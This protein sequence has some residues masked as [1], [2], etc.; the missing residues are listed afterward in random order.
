M[1]R[2]QLAEARV[3]EERLEEI[4]R[5]AGWAKTFGLPLEL[6]SAAE[7]QELFPP[8]SADGVL[9]AAYLPTDGYVDP[10]QLT[11]ALAEGARGGGE[12]STSTRALSIQAERARDGVVTDRGEIETDVIVNAGGMFA[13]ELGALA[14]VD[15]PIVPM[16]HE[17]LVRGRA[18]CRDMPTMRDP[19][20]LVYFGLNQAASS[21]AATSATSAVVAGRDPGGLQR[22]APG[23][24]L[25][26]FRA[27]ARERDPPR[28]LEEMAVVRL[29]NR[30]E[31][32]H[33]GRRVRP[34]ADRRPRLLDHG[35]PVP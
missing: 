30:P 6:I 17:Y 22:Q 24:G 21:W 33:A 23:G 10:S 12:V 26:P 7:A 18:G 4:A 2:G 1:A 25:A 5:Q 20:L 34:G 28:A 16:A 9:G 13:R 15:V 3:F 31:A 11:L 32:F 19:S 27:A 35:E 14:G 8:M 29:I